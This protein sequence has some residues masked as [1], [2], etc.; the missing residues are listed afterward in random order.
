MR[1][2]E[3]AKHKEEKL[4]CLDDLAVS[5]GS[6]ERLALRGVLVDFGSTL[7]YFDEAENRRYEA[8]L[9]STLSR[10]ECKRRLED[11][12]SVLASIYVGSTKGE[13]KNL[14]EFW[15]LVLKKLEIPENPELVDELENVRIGHVAATWELYDK[16]PSTLVSLQKK[17]K[18]A[19]V[20]NC[21]VGTDKVID[22][23]G[24]SDFFGCIILSYQVGVRKPHK[25]IYLEALKCLELEAHE[26]VFVADEIS[27]LEGAREVG[28]NTLL[29]RQGTDTFK[30][31][32]DTNFKPNFE[33]NHIADIT[34]FL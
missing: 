23:L 31:A 15:G 8:A 22:A 17:Y 21:A 14:Q 7:A 11:L 34:D 19:L 16:V 4:G 24:L 1:A 9:V 12:D 30:E 28:L 10:Y 29:V 6:L 2:L 32:K 25:H 5:V 18:L 3:P 33:C 20:S 27:D 26:C 13:L